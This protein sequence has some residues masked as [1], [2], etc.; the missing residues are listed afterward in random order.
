MRTALREGWISLLKMH[1]IRKEKRVENALL[2]FEGLAVNVVTKTNHLIGDEFHLH[3]PERLVVIKRNP[4]KTFKP[5]WDTI[6]RVE[7]RYR[8]PVSSAALI[9]KLL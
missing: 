5:R 1:L 8:S 9:G 2:S 4:W 7:F 3:D 6:T